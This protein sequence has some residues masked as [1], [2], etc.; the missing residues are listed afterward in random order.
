M[1]SKNIGYIPALDQIRGFAALLILFYHGLTLISYQLMYASPF[2]FE[3]WLEAKT[4]ISALIIDGH[5][6]VALF[7]VRSGFIFTIGTYGGE[8]KYKYFIGNRF[9]RTSPLFLLMLFAGIASFPG[10]F[11]IA[12]FLQTVFFLGN[13]KGAI[14][15]GQFTAMFWAVAVEWQF[16]L[17]FAIN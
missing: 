8:V 12:G 14:S 16:Y 15:A 3:H 10:Q 4:V 5:T 9:L 2:K 17:V 6:A 11:D 7:M 13:L 1:K